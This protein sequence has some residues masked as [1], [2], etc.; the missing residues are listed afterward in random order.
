MTF[1]H[2]YML[3]QQIFCPG[4]IVTR[5]VSSYPD[6]LDRD[7]LSNSIISPPLRL[8]LRIFR[9]SLDYSRRANCHTEIT[10]RP[11]PAT[12]IVCPGGGRGGEAVVPF[13]SARQRLSEGCARAW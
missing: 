2:L 3:S 7:K 5:P 12:C 13:A 4:R 6:N 1:G 9:S 8:V 10:V 11:P